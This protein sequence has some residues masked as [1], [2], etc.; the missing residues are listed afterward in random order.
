MKYKKN[1]KQKSQTEK[2]TIFTNLTNF[3]PN[4]TNTSN[5]KNSNNSQNKKIAIF[6]N[7][8]LINYYVRLPRYL[9]SIK[10]QKITKQ[11]VSTF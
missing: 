10:Y 9:P 3:I 11:I 7:Q 5:S 1:S 8:L 6:T 2:L 4:C